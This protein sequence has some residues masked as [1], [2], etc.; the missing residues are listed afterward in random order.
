VK[1]LH[2]RLRCDAGQ[3]VV[4]VVL[5][6]AV[7]VGMAALVVDG[8]SW[9]QADRQAQTAADAAALAGAQ[10]LPRRADAEDSADEYWSRNR[11]NSTSEDTLSFPD[12]TEPEYQITVKV[13]RKTDGFFA[14]VFD[15]DSITVRADA[16][17]QVTAPLE[18]KNVAPIAVKDTAACLVTE[19]SCF[20]QP[21]TL[22]FK[23]SDIASGLIGLINLAC[24]SDSSS[25]C[26][27][28]GTGGSDLTN[29]IASG[30]S[31]ALPSNQWYGT[32]TGEVDKVQKALE[33]AAEAEKVLLFPVWDEADAANRSFHVIGW[34]AFEIDS[35][36]EWKNDN[37]SCS[38]N[39]KVLQ[40]HFETFLATDLAAG[41][42]ISD[43][44]IDFGVHVITLTR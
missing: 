25:G 16:Q 5:V 30:Y 37:P 12:P 21:V 20:N 34:A 14:K 35:V 19:L 9:Y 6:L 33:D 24:H 43:P 23:E 13:T 28:G 40:G 17:A 36:I 7:L 1:S 4:F 38:P 15:I 18:M 26:G 39:C 2:A 44:N 11:D 27:S 22:N 32:K 3:A 41:G 29:W 42:T 10:D 8:G 31:G